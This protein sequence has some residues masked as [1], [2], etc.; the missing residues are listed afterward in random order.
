MV[1]ID[2]AVEHL[3]FWLARLQE[4]AEEHCAPLNWAQLATDNQG[5]LHTWSGLLDM[6]GA[7]APLVLILMGQVPCDTP[8]QLVSSS[9]RMRAF[10]ELG[11]PD[12][13]Q[14]SGDYS[15]SYVETALI[16]ALP[17]LM[18]DAGTGLL[19]PAFKMND[20]IFRYCDAIERCKGGDHEEIPS[21]ICGICFCH[22]LWAL[23]PFFG[24]PTLSQ[25]IETAPPSAAPPLTMDD[26]SSWSLTIPEGPTAKPNLA[27]PIPPSLE[28]GVYICN[29]NRAISSKGTPEV[30]LLY[31]SPGTSFSPLRSTLPKAR[32]SYKEE[33]RTTATLVHHFQEGRV[34]SEPRT[35]TVSALDLRISALELRLAGLGRKGTGSSRKPDET[36]SWGK[37][38]GPSKDDAGPSRK[39]KHDEDGTVP[40]RASRKHRRSVSTANTNVDRASPAVGVR[41]EQRTLGPLHP[42]SPP[43]PDLALTP[44]PSTTRTRPRNPWPL[45]EWGTYMFTH[46]HER[47]RKW[48]TLLSIVRAMPD[49][50]P[51]GSDSGSQSRAG[52]GPG[53]GPGLGPEPLAQR[54]E[55][56]RALFLA[57]MDGEP[58]YWNTFVCTPDGGMWALRRHVKGVP[59]DEVQE[60]ARAEELMIRGA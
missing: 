27:F 52:P 45:S 60:R 4:D 39:R 47:P 15:E 58:K 24:A 13:K 46:L 59:P 11:P 49:T 42:V 31:H 5:F 54:F 1:D 28:T 48:A 33:E 41:T 6:H 55:R 34:A 19:R 43:S 36:S 16:L 40:G 32:N 20:L 26:F 35:P 56:L 3:L 57:K 50:L 9:L 37:S 10:L 25:A 22:L 18:L 21:G 51:G 7:L 14:P 53:P 29:S 23:Q 38:Q 17:V 12:F 44:P 30:P 8:P 2:A